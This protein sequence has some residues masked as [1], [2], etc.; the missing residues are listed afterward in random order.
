MDRGD[1]EKWTL[2]AMK[3]ADLISKINLR[4]QSLRSFFDENKS[5]LITWIQKGSLSI[6]DQGLFAGA[7]FILNILLARWLEPAQY[8]AFALAYSLFLLLGV[9]HTAILT[10]PMMVFGAGRYAERFQKY[11]GILLYSHFTLMVPVGLILSAAAF[12]IG[13]VY[14]PDVQKA[15]FGLALGGPMILLLWLVRRAFYVRLQP[16]W[17]ALGGGFYLGLLLGATYLLWTAHRLSPATAF[18]GMGLSALLVSLLLIRRLHPKWMMV[19]NPTPRMVARV[20]WSYGRWALG[21]AGLMWFP[22][23]IYFVVLP[24]WLGLEG[25]G[26]LRA[27]MNLVM[28]MLHTISALS[29]LLLPLLAHHLR[30]G[31]R[32]MM[33]TMKLFFVLFLAGSAL[34]LLG[35]VIFKF[36]ILKWLYANKYRE[37]SYLAPLVG[38]LPLGASLTAVLGAALRAMEC[39]NSIFWCYIASSA[40]ALGGGIFLAATL[41]VQG[42]LWGLLLSS[43]TTGAMMF[44]FYRNLHKQ[45]RET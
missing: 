1:G 27:L 18:L 28:P 43:L 40:V 41:R 10:E 17:A 19:G 2:K 38:L 15:L 44:V 9:F 25:T 4:I 29:L 26:A 32:R 5:R 35:L 7:N 20:H 13:R 31:I 36:E 8:G 21:T 42:A 45:R 39:P 24:A 12:F 22:G 11:L 3:T 16:G 14:S 30:E 34:Y 37:F 33:H 23:N 6:L